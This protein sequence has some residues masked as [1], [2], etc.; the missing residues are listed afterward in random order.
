MNPTERE[1]SAASATAAGESDAFESR[2]M[3]KVA[4]RL[5]PFLL[6]GFFLAFVDRVN[7]G[8]ANATMSHDLGLS[9]A[10]FGRAAG[11]FFIGYFFFEVPSNLALNKFGARAW[12]ARIMFTW[13]IMS[14]AQAFVAGEAG[15]D[16][17]RFLLGIAEA[18]FLPGVIFFLTL[19][20]PSAYRARIFG[21]F[22]VSVPASF[23]VGAPISGPI[24]DMDGIGG[25]HGWQWMFLIEALPSLLMAFALFYCLTDRPSLATWL[26]PVER[27]WLQNCLDAERTNREMLFS[28][29]WV[30]AMVAPRVLLLGMVYICF[31]VP[32]FGLVFFLPQ[33]VKDFGLTNVQAGFA[34][35][36]PY[37][38]GIIGMI[39]W[40][41]HS[42]R[43]CER[44][45]HAV[46]SFAAMSS[47][48]AFAAMTASPIVKVA[49]LCIASWGLF[50]FLPV[51]WALPTA[52]L[53]GAGAAAG[54]ATINSIGALGGYFGPSIFGQLRDWTGTDLAGLT[55]LAACP[56]VGI[57]IVLVLGHNSLLERPAET[58]PAAV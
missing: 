40:G 5:I 55:F 31:T 26:T 4:S 11:I 54:I 36:I 42:D 58:A 3:A 56:I 25:L 33:I 14:A 24:L 44:K 30:K 9:A 39:H 19:W 18:G 43:T 22:L 27:K 7:V 51:F 38:V 47:G 52:F 8:F 28:M 57:V 32:Q 2:T 1:F 50:S 41:S 53:S 17:V 29:N 34:T 15:L 13:G 46:I 45:W 37:V 12:L 35:A 49:F 10:A 21:W 20:F 6:I 16:I 48:L 23:A